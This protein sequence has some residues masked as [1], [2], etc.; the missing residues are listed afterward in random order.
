MTKK[1]TRYTRYWQRATAISTIVA[2]FAIGALF[3]IATSGVA[4]TA[5]ASS[6]ELDR[7]NLAPTDTR[8]ISADRLSTAF[9]TVAKTIRPSMA[10]IR[11]VAKVDRPAQLPFNSR[12]FD[13]FDFFEGEGRQPRMSPPD[14]QRGAGSGFV[15][16]TDGYLLT[17]HHVVDRAEKIEVEV[18]DETYQARVIG[19]DPQTDLAASPLAA[20][21]IRVSVLRF[22]SISPSRSWKA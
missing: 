4:A 5:P 21:V 15:V 2:L 17:N 9:E 7:G 12:F 16:S 10:S 13:L 19:T 3:G 20:A 1:T 11:V 8:V 22:R 18:G 6:D 14:L